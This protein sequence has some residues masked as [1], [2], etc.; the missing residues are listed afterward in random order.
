MSKPADFIAALEV[1]TNIKV[2][3]LPFLHQPG[4]LTERLANQ[5][6][7]HIADQ[8]G[9]Q[10]RREYYEQCNVQQAVGR[11][12]KV[13]DRRITEQG[14]ASCGQR[15]VHRQLLRSGFIVCHKGTIQFLARMRLGLCLRRLDE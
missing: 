7:Q 10:R 12:G 2:A 4:Q 1:G 9:N 15:L 11:L 14:P 8:E 6:D 3:L 13:A 5:T